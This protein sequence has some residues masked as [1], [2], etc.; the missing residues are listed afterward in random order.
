[1]D[2]LRGILQ[3]ETEFINSII[4]LGSESEIA[5]IS[6]EIFSKNGNISQVINVSSKS[7]SVSEKVMIE[8]LSTFKYTLNNIPTEKEVKKIVEAKMKQHEKYIQIKTKK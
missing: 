3:L 2:S 6:A 7:W 5:V 4:Y 1:M 8:I